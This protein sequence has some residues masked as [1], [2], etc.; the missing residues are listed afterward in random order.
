MSSPEKY[1]ESEPVLS[2]ESHETASEIASELRNLY[3]NTA[4]KG[5]KFKIPTPRNNSEI[6]SCSEP[7]EGTTQ[8]LQA[9]IKAGQEFFGLVQVESMIRIPGMAIP[10]LVESMILTKHNSNERATVVA[11]INRG[12]GVENIGRAHQPNLGDQVSRHHF[13]LEQDLDGSILINDGGADG[14]PST[15]G[16]EIFE[17]AQNDTSN[18]AIIDGSPLQDNL[19]WSAEPSDIKKNINK[20]TF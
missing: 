18:G 17:K 8:K 19:F 1:R 12:Q 9:V 4:I 7:D 13:Y 20:S 5:E 16:T 6:G 14:K 2:A 3:Q 15:N 10:Q 11:V